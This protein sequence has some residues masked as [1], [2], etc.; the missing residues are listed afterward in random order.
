VGGIGMLPN[1]FQ[2]NFHDLTCLNS[3]T[4][5]IWCLRL[6]VAVRPHKVN[7]ENSA[8]KEACDVG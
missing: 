5:A 1:V 8:F 6:L 4:S 3:S 2:N 7:G